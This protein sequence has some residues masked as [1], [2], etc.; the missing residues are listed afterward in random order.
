MKM[1]LAALLG[2]GS[3]GVSRRVL[4]VSVICA[5]T[6]KKEDPFVSPV[7]LQAVILFLTIEMVT[8]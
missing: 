6:C 8:D 2:C 4:V 5:R 3:L 7:E 1:S